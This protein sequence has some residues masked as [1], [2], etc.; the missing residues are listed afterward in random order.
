[1]LRTYGLPPLPMRPSLAMLLL[2]M[3]ACMHDGERTH[4]T[5]PRTQ[6]SAPPAADVKVATATFALG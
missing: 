2:I 3:G 5:Q 6:L 1:M 4:M